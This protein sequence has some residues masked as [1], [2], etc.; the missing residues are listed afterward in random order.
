VVEAYRTGGG[1]DWSA[2]GADSREGQAAGNRPAFLRLLGQQWLPAISE[3]DQRLRAEPPAR[4]ADVGCGEG[5]SSIGMALAYPKVEVHGFDVDKPSIEAA[6][7]HAAEAGLDGRVRFEARNAGDPELAGRYDLVTAFECV[8]DMSNPVSALG[9]MRRLAA[10]G[11]TVLV[12]DE[13]V[14]DRFH[15]PGD[16]TERYHYGWS[17][18]CCL[19][20]GMSEQPSAMTGTVMRTDTLA[21]YADEAGFSGFEVL[22]IEEDWFRFYRLMP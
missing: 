22:P 13:P 4:I 16:D 17:V 20:A 6:R 12:A 18:T 3:I 15:A 2:Y 19:P 1:V 8:H 11:G 14:A 7:Q 9:A 10:E 21:R 5:W